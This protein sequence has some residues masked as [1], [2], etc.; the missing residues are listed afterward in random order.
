MARPYTYTETNGKLN[1]AAGGI[2][3]LSVN[4]ASPYFRCNIAPNGESVYIHDGS[5]GHEITRAEILAGVLGQLTPDTLKDYLDAAN[6]TALASGGGGGAKSYAKLQ[7][8]GAGIETTSTAFKILSQ[9]TGSLV[10]ASPNLDIDDNL[11]NEV[12]RYT[13]LDPKTFRVS[14]K[15]SL[16]ATGADAAYRMKLYHFDISYSEIADTEMDLSGDNAAGEAHFG[17]TETFF[18]LNRNELIAIYIADASTNNV[19]C[20]PSFVQLTLQEV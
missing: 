18:T 16:S 2:R 5:T 20:I 17:A 14:A 7:G 1:A 11:G 3:F 15:L 4:L 9:W 13:G 6:A 19:S 12:L 8:T 10:V